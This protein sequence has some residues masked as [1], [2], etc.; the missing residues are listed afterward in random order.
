MLYDIQ[1]TP[2]SLEFVCRDIPL[3]WRCVEVRLDSNLCTALSVPGGWGFY[4]TRQSAYD[5]R[6]MVSYTH[7]PPLHP[8]RCPFHSFVLQYESTPVRPEGLCQWKIPMI[9]SE[10]EPTTFRL[11][12]QCL[13]QRSKGREAKYSNPEAWR[14]WP[15]SIKFFGPINIKYISNHNCVNAIFS[16]SLLCVHVI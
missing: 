7:W 8:R 12:A 3:W 1:T 9:P 6:K 11:V 10:I 2:L 5:S 16:V 13:N 15:S 4:I 14:H